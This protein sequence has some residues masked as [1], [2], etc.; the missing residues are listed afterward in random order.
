MTPEFGLGE[1]KD[2]EG[3]KY[4]HQSE[5]H[6][7]IAVNSHDPLKVGDKYRADTK[8]LL[9]CRKPLRQLLCRTKREC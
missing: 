1:V 5:E 7:M 6:R 8:S 4:Y 2:I 3:T 9:Y